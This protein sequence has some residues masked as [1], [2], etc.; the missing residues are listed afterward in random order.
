MIKAA[1]SLAQIRRRCLSKSRLVW[2]DN[3]TE[4]GAISVTE[5]EDEI[6]ERR[7]LGVTE[8]WQ[9]PKID[10]TLEENAHFHKDFRKNRYFRRYEDE[11]GDPNRKEESRKGTGV[12]FTFS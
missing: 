3:S 10:F 7:E 5:N 9:P 6:S 2:S 1:R 4:G 12:I 8:S 11:D